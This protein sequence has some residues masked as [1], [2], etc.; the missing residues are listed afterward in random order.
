M[1]VGLYSSEVN[2]QIFEVVSK[3]GNAYFVKFDDKTMLIE[4]SVLKS[5]KSVYLG[6][7]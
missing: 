4:E 2:S 6:V 7:L 1:K 5:I 3:L